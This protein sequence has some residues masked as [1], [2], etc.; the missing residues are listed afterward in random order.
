MHLTVSSL[1]NRIFSLDFKSAPKDSKLS[2]NHSFVTSFKKTDI[3]VFK[4]CSALYDKFSR[5]VLIPALRRVPRE[6]AFSDSR[7]GSYLRE[8]SAKNRTLFWGPQEGK[9]RKIRVLGPKTPK[10]GQNACFWAILKKA[11]P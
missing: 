6:R 4:T 3:F 11:I 1:E 10:N 5:G 7:G 2:K 8:G 9:I